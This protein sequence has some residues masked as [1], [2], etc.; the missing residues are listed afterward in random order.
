M[1]PIETAVLLDMM[2]RRTNLF[3]RVHGRLRTGNRGM[4]WARQLGV[5]CEQ[6]HDRIVELE[7]ELAE[8]KEK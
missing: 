3:F 7:A 8:L 6:A 4:D 2:K 5:L 1:P